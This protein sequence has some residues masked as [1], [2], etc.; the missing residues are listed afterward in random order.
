MVTVAIDVD[1]LNIQQKPRVGSEWTVIQLATAF[2]STVTKCILPLKYPA[3]MILI[4]NKKTK[5]DK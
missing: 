1:E 5:D 3:M 2:F 4:P